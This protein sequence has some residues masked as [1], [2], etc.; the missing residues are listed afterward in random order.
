MANAPSIGSRD[1]RRGLSRRTRFVGL[2]FASCMLIT[3]L[4]GQPFAEEES[5]EV[6]EA[7]GSLL[8]SY[9][10]GRV[11]QTERDSETASGYY[12]IALEQDPNNDVVLKQVFF[13]EAQAGNWTG[14]DDYAARV[15]DVDPSNRIA[16]LYLGVKAF[17]AGAYERADKHFKEGAVGPIGELTSTL[18]RSWVL[19]AQRKTTAALDLLDTLKDSDWARFYR[20]YHRGLIASAGGEAELA[21]KDYAELFKMEPRTISVAMAYAAHADK[22]GEATLAREVLKANMTSNAQPHPIPLA[23]LASLRRGER[24][25]PLTSAAEGLSEAFYGLGEALTNEGGLDIG[26]VYIQLALYLQPSSPLA[27]AALANVQENTNQYDRAIDTYA[28][29]PNTSPIG[30]NFAL[31]RALNLNALDRSDE[32]KAVL[33]KLLEQPIADIPLDEPPVGPDT[34]QMAATLTPLA[35]GSKGD[36][37]KALQELLGKAGLPAGK[38]DGAYGKATSE[39][40]RKLQGEAK[41]PVTGA[42]DAATMKA[43]GERLAALAKPGVQPTYESE[44]Q[45][46][47]ALGNILRGR[48]EFADAAK[49]Y[50]EAINRI[51]KPGK[52]DWDQLYSRAVCYERMKMWPK[53]EAD[54][55]KAIELNPDEPLSLNYLGYS[56]VDQGIHLDKALDMIRKAVKLKPDD[57]YFIDSLGWAYYKLGRYEEAVQELERAVELKPDDAVLNDHLGDA[58]WRAGRRLEAKFQWSSALSSKPEPEDIPRLQ[59]KLKDGLM[60]DAQPAMG[61]ETPPKQASGAA[62]AAPQP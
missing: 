38:I 41:L 37:V 30:F 1:V 35:P 45:L 14:A 51:A 54:F 36:P 28:R 59:A 11:A 3:G 56:W 13:N 31:R 4:A 22:L 5:V 18:A 8:G 60:T 58:Y 40:V 57:G 24:L 53:A 9:L 23:A 44:I 47:T 15:V 32:A 10:A 16:Q 19:A 42:A 48:K 62:E 21:S 25:V 17:K 39:A 29:I 6:L 20:L 55:L 33:L 12:R 34:V 61:A 49:Y 2:T 43:L 52:E 27:L 50:T 46:Y 26:T 7:S